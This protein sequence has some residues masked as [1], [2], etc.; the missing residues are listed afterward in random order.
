[1]SRGC[2]EAEIEGMFISVESGR[3]EHAGLRTKIGL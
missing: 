2:R 3:M 1:M